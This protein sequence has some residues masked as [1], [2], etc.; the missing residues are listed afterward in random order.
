MRFTWGYSD[1]EGSVGKEPDELGKRGLR[2]RSWKAGEEG[3]ADG[4]VSCGGVIAVVW[5]LSAE[6]S[7]KDAATRK[8]ME[9][10]RGWQNE[11]AAAIAVGSPAS[12]RR[13]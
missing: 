9:D 5:A 3:R 10:G 12:R 8:A 13:R 11:P 1:G 4:N 2:A 6:T 7:D